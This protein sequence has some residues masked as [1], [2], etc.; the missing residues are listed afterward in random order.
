MQACLY[1]EERIERVC[2]LVKEVKQYEHGGLVVLQD[3]MCISYL[4]LN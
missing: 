4:S 3:E 2:V 1:G